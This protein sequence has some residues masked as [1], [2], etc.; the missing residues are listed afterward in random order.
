MRKLSRTEPMTFEEARA[1]Y[2]NRFT[3]EHVPAWA[4]KRREDGTY[5]APQ[6]KSDRE[7]YEN[8]HFPP[9]PLC[10]KGHC[11]SHSQTWPLGKSL[12]GPYIPY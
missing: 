12:P 2:V 3:M 8:T 6:Y 1:R 4:M 11:H 5:H 7:W 10:D 9:H